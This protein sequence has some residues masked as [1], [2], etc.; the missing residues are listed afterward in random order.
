VNK[1]KK[2]TILK[3]ALKEINNKLRKKNTGVIS[4]FWKG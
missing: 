1:Y 3:S 4:A 2:I